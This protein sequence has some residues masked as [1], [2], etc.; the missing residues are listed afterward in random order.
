MATCFLYACDSNVKT[1]STSSDSVAGSNKIVPPISLAG[2]YQMIIER[3]SAFLQLKD[4]A[5]LLTGLLVYHRYEKD[6]NSGIFTGVVTRKNQLEGWYHFMSEG[7]IS[8][9]QVIFKIS[10]NALSEGYG[11]IE[12]RNDTAYFK[13]QSNLRFEVNHPFSKQVCN[14]SENQ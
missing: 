11:D 5:G 12:L 3:D 7:M 9:R 4:S 1:K 10:D 2:C 13:Y 8:V 6:S 14:Q